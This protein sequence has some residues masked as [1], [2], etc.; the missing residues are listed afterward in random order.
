MAL[1]WPGRD[2]TVEELNRRHP[3]P[4]LSELGFRTVVEHHAAA[5]RAMGEAP[6]II[7]HS[8]GGLV[9]QSLLHRGLGAVGVAIDS[10]PPAGVLV[11]SLSL[12]RANW[13]VLNPFLPSSRPYR[14]SLSR[15]QYAFVNGMP[16]EV[17]KSIYETQVVPESLR[18]P[19]GSRSKSEGIDF[20]R[21]HPPLLLTAGSMDQV[22]PPKLNREN[23]DRYRRGSSSTVE[24]KEFPGRNHFGVLG[25]P[26]WEE[27][28]DFAVDWAER[29]LPE[30]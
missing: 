5:I 13:P 8:M 25:G 3:D 16:L 7:G 12:L 27:V 1:P 21:P 4:H 28:A 19:R 15:F 14:M 24:F 22:I 9:T 11:P 26:N 30:G 20:T 10:A 18:V 29:H 6:I 17:Q 23:F 2:A